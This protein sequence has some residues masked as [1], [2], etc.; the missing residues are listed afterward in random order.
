MPET[1]EPESQS[2]GG[3][4]ARAA[5]PIPPGNPTFPAPE[6]S[7]METICRRGQLVCLLLFI[8]I[9][10]AAFISILLGLSMR[11]DLLLFLAGFIVIVAVI[12]MSKQSTKLRQ[13]RRDAYALLVFN[14]ARVGDV[15]KYAVFLRPFY[16]TG[17]IEVEE[18]SAIDES[19][20]W[21]YEFEST[22]A[23][24][25]AQLMPIVALGRPGEAIG[26]GRI[27]ADESTWRTAAAKLMLRAS[28]IICIPS[29][30]PGTAWELEQIVQSGYLAKTVFFMPLVVKSFSA[31]QE[32]R[33]DWNLV[34]EHMRRHGISVPNYR[35][36]SPNDRT[37][38]SFALANLGL[39]VHDLRASHW[40]APRGVGAT[41]LLFSV[42]PEGGCKEEYINLR[43]PRS[44]QAVIERLTGETAGASSAV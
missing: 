22:I 38:L 27:L 11:I 40:R 34:A 26:A 18:S 4:T 37:E 23:E 32:Q 20:K 7:R 2:A 25:L 16:L 12:F 3:N 1:A 5:I 9:W 17:R 29:A 42:T 39:L 43:H 19:Q 35:E 28:L 31:L 8:A 14:A 33:N 41:G 21:T 30:H 15:P 6:P 24:G 13:E 10:L 36:I 44:L